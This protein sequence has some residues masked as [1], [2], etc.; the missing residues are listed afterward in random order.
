MWYLYFFNINEVIKI[1]E[2]YDNQ[3]DEAY[4]Y[5]IYMC[6][7]CT[8]FINNECTKKLSVIKCA[9]NNLKNSLNINDAR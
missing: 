6:S 1:R 3:V 2:K 4:K 7:K 8:F 5:K 9:K